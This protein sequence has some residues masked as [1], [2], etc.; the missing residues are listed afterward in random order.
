MACTVTQL[1]KE[2]NSKWLKINN[3]FISLGIINILIVLQHV[4]VTCNSPKFDCMHLVMWLRLS[5]SDRRV[6]IV[7]RGVDANNYFSQWQCEIL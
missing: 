2:Y 7:S 5:L 1:D 4:K 3:K 6:I